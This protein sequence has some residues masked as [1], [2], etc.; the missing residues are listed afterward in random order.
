M[1]NICFTV[2]NRFNCNGNDKGKTND[3]MI[4]LTN[5]LGEDK[6]KLRMS[7]ERHSYWQYISLLS[8][9]QTYEFLK[10][11]N[12]TKDQLFHCLQII[13]YPV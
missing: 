7:L 11:Q 9:R 5:T 12:F 6:R 2:F 1:I 13:L 3:I 8:I 10:K 4:Y